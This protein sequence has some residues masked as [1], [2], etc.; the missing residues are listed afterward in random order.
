MSK[1]DQ[2]VD[3]LLRAQEQMVSEIAQCGNAG[4][5]G[6]AQNYAPVLVNITQALEIMQKMQGGKTPQAVQDRMAAVRA[7]KQTTQSV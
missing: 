4:G 2:A 3:V 5:V 1:V 7:A 6:R